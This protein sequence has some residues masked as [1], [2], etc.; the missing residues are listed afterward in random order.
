MNKRQPLYLYV[1]FALIVILACSPQAFASP[2]PAPSRPPPTATTTLSA[3][4]GE[5]GGNLVPAGENIIP[6]TGHSMKPADTAPAPGKVTYDVKSTVTAAS[7]G[8]SYKI[9]R[10]ERPFLKDMTYVADLD[11][12]TFNVSEDADWYYISIGL[13]GKDPN[14]SLGINYG[15]EIDLDADGFGDYI[16]WAHPPY[17]TQWD[18]KSMQVFTDS[19]H[20][21]AGLSSRRSDAG[22]DANGYETLVFDG[23]DLQTADPDLAW[24]R[25]IGGQGATVQ[26]AFK[27]SLTGT[28]FMLG[29]VAD[30]GLKDISKFDY[31]DYFKEAEAGS[32]VRNNPYFPVGSLY[33][34]DN[35]FW[36]AYGIQTPGSEPKF[37]PANGSATATNKSPGNA[38]SPSPTNTAPVTSLVTY[39]VAT[40]TDIIVT[41]PTD[42]NPTSEPPT[43]QPPTVEPPTQEPPTV[44]PPTVEPPTPEPPTAVPP[45][46]PTVK[47]CD[48]EPQ[49][50]N[51]D[52]DTCQCR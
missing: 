37:C 44:D 29:V 1:A 35:T 39:P 15:A 20:D 13:N 27:K 42:Q 45:P 17:T 51:Y 40:E 47:A 10:F 38:L 12:V 9:N 46:P 21:S 24:V 36:E 25:M 23:S 11:I 4:P 32:S 33:A 14:N 26:F 41:V 52:P 7:Y 22:H 16:L 19:D 3:V 8:D 34:V 6:V 30:A 50:S 5:M 48:P 43:D 31:N 2:A 18:T 28:V 49:C